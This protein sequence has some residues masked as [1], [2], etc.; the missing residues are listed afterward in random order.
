MARNFAA[1][2]NDLIVFLAAQPEVG[3]MIGHI[4]GFLR[5]WLPL[6]LEDHRSYATVAVGCTGGQHRSVYIT[7]QLARAFADDWNARIR[8]READGWPAPPTRP[9]DAPPQG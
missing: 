6:M 3:Q 5:H 8:H 2:Y 7:E 1:V 9:V 4:D